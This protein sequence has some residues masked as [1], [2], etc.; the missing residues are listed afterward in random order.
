MRTPAVGCLRTS[1][2]S[3]PGTVARR[4]CRAPRPPRWST[5]VPPEAVRYCGRLF[6]EQELQPDP[7]HHRRGPQPPSVRPLA[8]GVRTAALAACQRTTEGHE[9]PGGDAAHAPRRPHPAAGAAPAPLQRHPAP[10]PY[11]A[12]GTGVADHRPRRC[13]AGAAGTTA[14]RSARSAV[15]ARVRGPLPLPRLYAAAGSTDALPGHQPAARAGR[16]SALAPAPGR[17]LPAT[18]SSAGALP[19]AKPACS[20]S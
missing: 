19:N 13:A 6:S 4:A 10:P 3:C 11:P 9:L 2:G 8:G 16:S 14:R 5:A 7:H 15:V 17:R 1:S 20:W 12:G 18:A